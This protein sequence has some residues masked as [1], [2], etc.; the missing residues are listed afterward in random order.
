M[1]SFLTT[2]Q[3]TGTRPTCQRCA[4]RGLNCV[5]APDTRVRGLSRT[6]RSLKTSQDSYNDGSMPGSPVLR[7]APATQVSF[8]LPGKGKRGSW[9]GVGS[10]VARGEQALDF[11]GGPIRSLPGGD[12]GWDDVGHAVFETPES[13]AIYVRAR[14]K[15]V[16]V[17]HI[18]RSRDLKKPVQIGPLAIID[19]ALEQDQDPSTFASS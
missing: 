3:C 15:T 7:S 6:Y 8:P 2:I 18:S 4:D 13:S 19:P 16:S 1:E 14:S 5:W 12:D 9:H 10:T 17:A 11:I